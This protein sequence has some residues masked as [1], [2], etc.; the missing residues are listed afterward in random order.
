MKFHIR[1]DLKYNLHI[2]QTIAN[3]TH[4][5]NKFERMDPCYIITVGNQ[6]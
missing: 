4:D 1:K 2:V 5:T 6:K 3:L